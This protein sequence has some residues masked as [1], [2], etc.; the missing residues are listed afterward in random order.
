[1]LST[2]T[3]IGTL[4]LGGDHCEKENMKLVNILNMSFKQKKKGSRK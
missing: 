1:M 4:T 2:K 3:K